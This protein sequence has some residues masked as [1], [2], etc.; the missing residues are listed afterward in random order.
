MIFRQLFDAESS[1]YTYLLA[2]RAGGQALLIDPVL[3]Q[4]QRDRKLL[5]EL[6]LTLAYAL[7][8]HVHADHVTAL[9]ALRDATGCVTLMGAESK[10]LCVSRTLSDGELLECDG[11]AL[12]AL[13]TPG[14]TDDS[15]CFVV[16]N[17]LFSGD[18]LLIRGSG[19]ADFQGGDAGQQYDS[20]FG[21]V[22]TLPGETRVFPGHDYHG[23]TMS[24]LAEERA[25]NP[26]LQVQ[27]REAYIALM[28]ALNLPN[29]KLMDIA[30][31]ANLAC[32]KVAG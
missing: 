21:K 29:P 28:G 13:H 17:S 26:R 7:D 1:T 20:I 31:P 11:L 8:T 12:T 6:G 24:T 27:S 2:A 23:H 15:Y 9:G 18:T 14:H 22:L 10:A 19:R 32:G 30:V 4:V 3:E 5:R 16:G 25:H